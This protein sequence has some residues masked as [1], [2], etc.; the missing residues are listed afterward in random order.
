M[1]KQK[2]LKYKDILYKILIYSFIIF[3]LSENIYANIPVK[4]KKYKEITVKQH[5]TQ[6][7]CIDNV[8]ISSYSHNELSADVS[9][10]VFDNEFSDVVFI[11]GVNCDDLS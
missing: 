9:G 2:Q 3:T 11:C 7:E 8:Q 10:R 6:Q 1:I 5:V 4:C